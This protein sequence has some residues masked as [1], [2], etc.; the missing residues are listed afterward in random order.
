MSSLY[1]ELGHPCRLVHGPE[2]SHLAPYVSSPPAVALL[3]SLE[4]AVDPGTV[5]EVLL[6]LA[7]GTGMVHVTSADV[8]S[9]LTEGGR[10]SGILTDEGEI[11]ADHVILATGLG[12]AALLET[13][14]LDLPMDNRPGLLVRTRPVDV[15]MDHVISSPGLHCWQMED[16]RILAGEDTTRG[17]DRGAVGDNHG[18][19]VDSI[20]DKLD[21]M[22]A[23][24]GQRIEVDTYR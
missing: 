20:R 22:L 2:F 21:K 9:L 17:D 14:G 10:V 11:P 3:N 1:N 24:M 18:E 6:Q 12:T 8:M 13:V 5:S 23:G 16:G 15:I 7:I 19:M 4:C